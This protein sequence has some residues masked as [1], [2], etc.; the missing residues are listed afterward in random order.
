MQRISSAQ[1]QPILIGKPGSHVKLQPRHRQDREIGVTKAGEH[2]Q[3]LGAMIYFD[4]SG[5]QLD[6]KSCRKL[7]DN[8]VADHQII[9]ILLAEPHLHPPSFRLIRQQ[10]N[11][12]RRI[13]IQHQ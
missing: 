8:P 3:R 12:H 13:Q 4:S 9:R 11:Q 2:R 1:T 7:G 5:P 6:S 10:G